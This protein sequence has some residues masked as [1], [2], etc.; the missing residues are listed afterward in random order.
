VGR[1]KAEVAAEFIMGRVP[2]VTVTPYKSKIQEK[3]E[4]FY[5]QFNIII[6]GLDN[7]EARRWLNSLLVNMV[8]YDS[9][10]SIDPTTIIPLI[11]GGTE[12]LKGQARVIIPK[13][14]SCFECTLESFP[15]QKAFPMCTIAETPRIP[16]HCIAYAYLLEWDRNFPDKKL[17]KDNPDHLNWIYEKALQRSITYGIEGVTYFK[18]IGVVKNIIPAVASTNAIISAVCVNEAIKL[19]TFYSQTMN[20]YF[21]YMGSEGIYTPTFDYERKDSC[22]VCCDEVKTRVM[23][24]NGKMLL[25]EFI[26]MLCDDVS[27]QLKKPS[28]VAENVSLYMPKPPSL[29]KVLRKNLDVVLD[30]LIKSGEIVTITDEM[31]N[32]AYLSVQLEFD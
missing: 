3:D 13:I 16:E 2:G 12:G 23:N 28:L 30:E 27:L 8:N 19:L 24:V 21:M 26:Q 1:G 6:S 10:G 4:D 15:P 22:I 31:L 9:D 32:I 20:N 18:T 11:D 29:E 14:T 7:I 17:D 5:R 25:K